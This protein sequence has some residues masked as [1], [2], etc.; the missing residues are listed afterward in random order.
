MRAGDARECLDGGVGDAE[1]DAGGGAEHDAVVLHRPAHAR[2]HDQK[3][4]QTEQAGLEGDHRAWENC[5]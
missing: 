4:T 1:E 2:T 3:A 5:E